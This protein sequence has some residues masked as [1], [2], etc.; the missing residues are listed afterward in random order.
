MID[1]SPQG[2]DGID[3]RNHECHCDGH[4]I[5]V[6]QYDAGYQIE[7]EEYQQRR[8]R[9]KCRRFSLIIIH[10][11]VLSPPLGEAGWGLLYLQR[12]SRLKDG[13]FLIVF[14]FVPCGFAVGYCNHLFRKIAEYFSH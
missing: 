10:S 6:L 11:S 1:A 4:L 7:K 5:E 2:K 12:Y 8:K 13:D 14:A 3:G 9:K